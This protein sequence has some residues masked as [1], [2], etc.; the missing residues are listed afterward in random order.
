MTDLKL[1]EKESRTTQLVFSYQ[2]GKKVSYVL[3]MINL[4]SSFGWINVAVPREVNVETLVVDG[5]KNHTVINGVKQ[6]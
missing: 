5:C 6:G 2:G 1:F 4:V 3:Q